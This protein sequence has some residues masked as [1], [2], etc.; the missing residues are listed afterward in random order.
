MPRLWNAVDL[1]LDRVN[2]RTID[3]WADY[4]DTYRLHTGIFLL[5]INVCGEWRDLPGLPA[6]TRFWQSL[7]QCFSHAHTIDMNV[8]GCA[9]DPNLKSCVHADRPYLQSFIFSV[10]LDLHADARF[11]FPRSA[12]RLRAVSLRGVYPVWDDAETF[13]KA[14]E[15]AVDEIDVDGLVDVFQHMPNVTHLTLTG[16][17]ISSRSAPPAASLR[18]DLVVQLE[19]K[20]GEIGSVS[21]NA[22]GPGGSLRAGY[23]HANYLRH[24]HREQSRSGPF[25]RAARGL[26]TSDRYAIRAYG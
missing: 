2:S 1:D 21:E 17:K 11:S 3:S 20:I 13:P 24:C 16:F 10:N 14:T 7:G 12:P 22:S 25:G 19:L 8:Q 15:V 5:Y 6:A 4:L 9:L 18:N 23:L 26:C